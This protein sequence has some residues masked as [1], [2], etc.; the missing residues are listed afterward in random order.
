MIQNLKTQ[1]KKEK[2]SYPHQESFLHFNNFLINLLKLVNF[3]YQLKFIQ[4]IK[5]I[6]DI[7]FRNVLITLK[8]QTTVKRKRKLWENLYVLKFEQKITNSG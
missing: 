8:I 2:K 5:N 3:P 6:I 7:I 4:F 1:Y